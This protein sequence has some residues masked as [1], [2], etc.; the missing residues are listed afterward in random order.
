M[1]TIRQLHLQASVGQ[2]VVVY[3]VNGIK[4]MGTLVAFGEDALVLSV[5]G[6]DLTKQLVN[7]T[8]ISTVLPHAER[9]ED[10]T[11]EDERSAGGSGNATS[12]QAST[13]WSH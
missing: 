6:N 5:R 11:P 9:S 10:P 12:S 3:L 1:K 4:L 13:R 7:W 2:L 8:A